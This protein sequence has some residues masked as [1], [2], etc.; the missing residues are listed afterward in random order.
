MNQR[1]EHL[2]ALFEVVE[3]VEALEARREQHDVAG[4]GHGLRPKDSVAQ[5]RNH[6]AV[7]ES[8]RRE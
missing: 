4:A 5:C 7:S 2:T 3:L 6:R 1:G 8:L